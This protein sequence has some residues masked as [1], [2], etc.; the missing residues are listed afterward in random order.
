MTKEALIVFGKDTTAILSAD[1]KLAAVGFINI[2]HRVFKL[3]VRP[4]LKGKEQ[5]LLGLF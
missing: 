3:P 5:K 4:W 2:T 1:E